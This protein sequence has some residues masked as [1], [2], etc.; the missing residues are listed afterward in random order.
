MSTPEQDN[1]IKSILGF[2]LAQVLTEADQSS[3]GEQATASN[4]FGTAN[5]AAPSADSKIVQRQPGKPAQAKQIGEQRL[6]ELARDPG[7]AHQAWRKLG[8]LDRIAV[9][10]RMRQR[11]GAA[12]S[13]QFLAVAENGKP[14]IETIYYQP[15]TGPTP[16]QLTAKGYQLAGKEI[17][18]NAG[19]DIDVWVHPTGKTVRRDVSTWKPGATPPDPQP[20]TEA[21]PAEPP[22]PSETPE[23]PPPTMDEQQ[24]LAV[25][26]LEDLQERNNELQDA[27]RATPFA[28]QK[29]QQA[30]SSWA[31][32]RTEL[33]SMHQVDMEAVYPGFW[34][35]VD[36]ANSEN[37]DLLKKI[38]ELDPDFN[39]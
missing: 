26:L 6:S 2:D 21:P 25:E 16:D 15:G 1:Y 13:Q 3:G 29:A 31:M 4:Q 32:S 18:G 12:F 23:A 5:I 8:T 14:Q 28:K 30:Q 11:Y 22:T 20:T 17:T 10:E 39:L 7:A 27:I 36:D 38:Y 9:A 35:E 33:R 19:I 37:D 34:D 24:A